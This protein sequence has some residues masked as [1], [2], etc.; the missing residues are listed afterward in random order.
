MAEIPSDELFTT[1]TLGSTTIR[2]KYLSRN[3]PLKADQ[4]LA[5][6]S[7]IP[8]VSLRKRPGDGLSVADAKKAKNDRVSRKEYDRLRHIAYHG[9]KVHKDIVINT[10]AEYDPWAPVPPKVVPKEFDFLEEKKPISEPV[11]LKHKPI[12]LA[13]DGREVRAVRKP[14]AEKSYNPTFDDWA[15]RLEREGAKEVKKEQKRLDDAALEADRQLKIKEA[16][17]EEENARLNESE[18]ESEWEGIASESEQTPEWML[19]KKKERKTPAQRNKVIRRKEAE[20]QKRHEEHIRTKEHE[21]E[22][23]K[24][25]QKEMREKQRLRLDALAKREAALE[26]AES[27]DDGDDIKLRRRKPFGRAPIPDAPLEVLLV[28]DLPDSLR[29]LK[30]EGNP[31]HDRYRSLL[32]RG[33]VESRRVQPKKGRDR[34]YTEKWTYKDWKLQ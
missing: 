34:K 17:A 4:I 24:A 2:Q 7:A 16:Q 30:P 9:D 5:Q 31:L 14:A 27:S 6:R 20:S 12:S 10:D 28:E 21:V 15:A 19:K 11:T 22:R 8:A 32:L 13:A 25:L 29:R 26:A 23:V 1:D 18:W 33:K 3:K